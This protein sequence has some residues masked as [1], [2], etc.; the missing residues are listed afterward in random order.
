MRT[1]SSLSLLWGIVAPSALAFDAFRLPNPVADG[2]LRIREEPTVLQHGEYVSMDFDLSQG[3]AS[4][5]S[6]AS[7]PYPDIVAGTFT[8]PLDHFDG[9]TNLTFEQRYWYSLRHYNASRAPGTPSPVYVL[10]SGETNAEG[11]LP[12]LD[13]GIVDLLASKTGGIGVV[14]EHRYYGKSYPPREAFGPGE[15][16][17]VDELRWLNNRQALED[18]NNFARHVKLQ[19]VSE[20]MN[21]NDQPYIAYGGSYPGARAAHLRVLFPEVWYGA[22]A[23]SAVIAAVESFPEYFYPL[24]RGINTTASQ[25]LQAAVAAMDTILAPEPWKGSKQPNRDEGKTKALLELAGLKGLTE[26]ADFAQ[27]VT[28]P[29]GEYQSVNWDDKISPPDFATFIQR[30]VH[31]DEKALAPLRSKAKEL[32]LTEEALPDE[33]LRLISYLR[34]TVIDP[35]ISKNHTADECFGSA[36]YTSFIENKKL[37]SSKAWMFQVCTQWGYHQVAP[38]S[39]PPSD[40][41]VFHSGGPKMLSSLV[42]LSYSSAFCRRGFPPGKHFTIPARPDIDAVNSLGNFSLGAHTDRLGFID[43]EFDPWRPATAHSVDFAG[44]KQR[45]HTLER[46]F[47]LVANGTHHWDENGPTKGGSKPP[48]QV[49]AVHAEMI[50]AVQLWVRGWKG[51]KSA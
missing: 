7:H 23:S 13:H 16:W 24:A 45:A 14:L 4:F 50:K 49:E 29:L 42:D 47:L 18:S 43:G 21:S 38:P 48:G 32:G 20:P 15:G 39:Y 27:L 1:L 30:M 17:G 22:F 40:P 9:S 37:T 28:L 34:R 33:A 46:P 10:D 31:T 41:P 25:A 35:C 2:W 12:Y 11:R 51:R 36:D 3:D 26:P 6:T 44:V 19:G 5:N 8:Q